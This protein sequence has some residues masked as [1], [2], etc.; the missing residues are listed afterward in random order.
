VE[1]GERVF[2][3]P[4]DEPAPANQVEGDLVRAADADAALRLE[5][6]QAL[7]DQRG[8]VLVDD[9]YLLV[10]CEGVRDVFGA[11][12]A[13]VAIELRRGAPTPGREPGGNAEIRPVSRLA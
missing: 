5:L 6:V 13:V 2:P 11:L 8:I 12:A 4:T 10:A 9:T 1:V 3:E 7:A